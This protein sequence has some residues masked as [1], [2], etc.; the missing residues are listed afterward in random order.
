[1]SFVAT[2]SAHR[3]REVAG[4]RI[5]AAALG[6]GAAPVLAAG[7]ATTRL[8]GAGQA[9]R[10]PGERWSGPPWART[11][12]SSRCNSS[13]SPVWAPSR[14][15]RLSPRSGEAER[16]RVCRGRAD[17]GL[18]RCRARHPDTR[19]PSA[20]HRPPWLRLCRDVVVCASSP[21]DRLFPSA[22]LSMTSLD[23]T[24]SAA[25]S[26][27]GTASRSSR[28]LARCSRSGSPPEAEAAFPGGCGGPRGSGPRSPPAA[29]S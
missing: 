22:A 14:F 27:I 1:M 20:G 7:V 12:G 21:S 24:V 2:A 8:R 4:A 9:S 25:S 26:A 19:P 28:P 18:R 15:G 16:T 3:A 6:F 11:A 10:S 17:V 13:S 5:P 23:G 29:T